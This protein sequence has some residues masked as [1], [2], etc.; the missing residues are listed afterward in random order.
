MTKLNQDAGRLTSVLAKHFEPTLC[1]PGRFRTVAKSVQH[2]EK[3]SGAA[4]LHCDC[5]ITARFLNR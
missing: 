2:S 5:T 4:H 3:R 1:R